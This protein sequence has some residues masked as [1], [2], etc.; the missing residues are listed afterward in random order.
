MKMMSR[1]SIASYARTCVARLK[2]TRYFNSRG[3]PPSPPRSS[4][5][6]PYLCAPPLRR[7]EKRKKPTMSGKRRSEGRLRRPSGCLTDAGI[8]ILRYHTPKAIYEPIS[9]ANKTP[10]LRVLRYSGDS[11][12]GLLLAVKH[13]SA[14]RL[15]FIAGKEISM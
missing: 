1:M 7:A 12:P 2:R 9:T 15:N 11:P 14:E 8:N 3:L 4:R 13:W 6:S 10:Y 5:P